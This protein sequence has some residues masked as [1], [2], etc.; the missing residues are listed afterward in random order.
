MPGT[1]AM[2][3][4]ISHEGAECVSLVVVSQQLSHRLRFGLMRG[5]GGVVMFF[6]K[7]KGQSAYASHILSKGLHKRPLPAQRADERAREKLKLATTT[8][9]WVR[10]QLS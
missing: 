3:V 6:G 1:I 2:L 4:L 5:F 9:T 8:G 7:M 10:L